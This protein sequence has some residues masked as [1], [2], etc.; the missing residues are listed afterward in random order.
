[1]ARTMAAEV[2]AVW[3]P[4]GSCLNLDRPSS[5]DVGACPWSWSRSAI[6]TLLRSL[7]VSLGLAIGLERLF[8]RDDK[9]CDGAI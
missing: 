6:G 1:M 2:A 4:A 3:L 9:K 5:L 8:L 7:R